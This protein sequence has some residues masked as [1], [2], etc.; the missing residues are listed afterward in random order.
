MLWRAPGYFIINAIGSPYP[1]T[2][3]SCLSG[4]PTMCGVIGPRYLGASSML[5]ISARSHIPTSPVM[6][7]I[8]RNT[9]IS[10]FLLLHPLSI[11]ASKFT[12]LL[13]ARAQH[14]G[15]VSSSDA[16]DP[17]PSWTRK[18]YDNVLEAG[19]HFILLCNIYSDNI[20]CYL[21]NNRHMVI[22]IRA[23]Q[24]RLCR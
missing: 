24:Y 8:Q 1:G 10:Q 11:H 23:C 6:V 5:Y 4:I 15:G 9:H 20:G 18:R 3:T 2:S 7:Y 13:V 17:T 19:K 12:W 14:A 21:S 16:L 22:S